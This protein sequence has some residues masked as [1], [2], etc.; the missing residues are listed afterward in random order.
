MILWIGMLNKA[1]RFLI[2]SKWTIWR[3]TWSCTRT[4]TLWK[5]TRNSQHSRFHLSYIFILSFICYK[6]FEIYVIRASIILMEIEMA[7]VVGRKISDVTQGIHALQ[8]YRSDRRSRSVR[9]RARP[10]VKDSVSGKKFQQVWWI[11]VLVHVSKP[12]ILSLNLRITRRMENL[13]IH[14]DVRVATLYTGHVKWKRSLPS[15]V[16]HTRL[17]RCV[18]VS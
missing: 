8:V 11:V 1:F 14:R 4:N 17:E 13:R 6:Y 18:P 12:P 2:G 10:K 15:I 5:I 7:R 3:S 16:A 9:G